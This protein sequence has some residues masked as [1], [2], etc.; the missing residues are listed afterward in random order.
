MTTAYPLARVGDVSDWISIGLAC[1]KLGMADEIAAKLDG[2]EIKV[3]VLPRRDEIG[4]R[5]Q[6]R[7]ARTVGEEACAAREVAALDADEAWISAGLARMRGVGRDVDEVTPEILDALA[8]SHLTWLV[9]AIVATYNGLDADA[10][11]GFFTQAQA[12]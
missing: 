8:A 5:E 7:A 9:A 2:V 4:L 6:A 11:A 3:K 12:A 1:R 10:R